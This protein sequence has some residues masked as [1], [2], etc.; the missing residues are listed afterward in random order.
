MLYYLFLV[1]FTS[2]SSNENTIENVEKQPDGE[3]LDD[4]TY[5]VNSQKYNFDIGEFK[6][7]VPENDDDLKAL[8][9]LVPHRNGNGLYL[10]YSSEWQ[11]FAKQEKLALCGVNLKGNEYTEAS[12]GSGKALLMAIE[13]I[14]KKNDVLKLIS[15]PLIF[16]GYSAGGVFSY[17]FS[18]YKPQSVAGFVNIRGGSIS[19]LTT[20]NNNNIPG[21]ILAGEHE[22]ENRINYIKNIILDKRSQ[23]ALWNFAIEPNATHFSNLSDSDQLA[24]I[25]FKSILKKKISDNNQI[26]ILDEQEGWLGDPITKNVST[27][28]DYPDDKNKA[29]WLIDEIYAKAWKEFQTKIN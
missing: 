29:F 26:N 12:D 1:L 8:L 3:F 11:E 25:F 9:V 2:C 21:L 22:G 28:S 16:R 19:Q 13:K 24:K 23:S 10:S 18:S 20:T 4:W 17:N 14:A 15:L 5:K 27:Y 7:W 6:V